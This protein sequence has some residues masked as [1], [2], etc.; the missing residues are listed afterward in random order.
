MFKIKYSEVS[1]VFSSWFSNSVRKFNKLDGMMGHI[2]KDIINKF[3]IKFDKKEIIKN[4]NTI[5]NVIVE[6]VYEI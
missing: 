6:E 5:I 4:I 2:P 1:K 3:K